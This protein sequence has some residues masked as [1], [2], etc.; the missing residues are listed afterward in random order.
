[1]MKKKYVL[2]FVGF[3]FSLIFFSCAS[4]KQPK[5][6]FKPLDYTNDDVVNAEI[7]RI[8]NLKTTEPVKALWRAILLQNDD[9]I[10]ECQ[11]IVK[12]QYDF[13]LEEK[14]YFEARTYYIS[15]KN[16]SWNFGKNEE[17]KLKSLFVQD[18]PGFSINSQ[19]LPKTLNDCLN[20]TVTIWVDRGVK[21]ENGA[22]YADIVLGSGF[23]IDERGYIVTNH[24]VIESMV[25]PKYEGYSRLYI[26]LLSDSDTKIPAKVVGY[27]SKLDLALLK[28]EIKPEF[29]LSLGSSSDLSVGDKVSAIGTPLGLEGTLTSGIVSATGRKL[30]TLGDVFQIDAAVNSGNS[31]G[32]LIDENMKVQAIVFAGILQYQGLNFAIPVEY[33]KQEL[34]ILYNE[35]EVLHPWIGAYGH[36]KKSGNKKIGLEIQ[37]TMPGSPSY[38]NGLKSGDVITKIEDSNI[39]SLED[40]QLAFMSYQ[41]GTMVKITYLENGEDETSKCIYLEKRP[42]NPSTEFYKSDLISGSFI[43]LFGMELASSSSMNHKEYVVRNVIKGSSADELNFSENDK[44]TVQNV[45]LNDENSIIFAQIYAQRKK[46]GFL[47]VTMILSTSYDS[48]YYF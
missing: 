2:V 12:N 34:P 22:G 4:V 48:P 5:E 31:G 21:I 17:E 40:L 13:A 29:I 1:M 6:V 8:N 26:K 37:Y 32:P 20:A 18:V 9:V 30:L 7:E 45:V 39:T 19:K 16:S 25:N 35:D 33:L 46:K 10:K 23:F 38:L 15:L 11:E 28:A 24:H 44:I 36:T 27:D 47:D 42:E 14:N 41:P 43:P 3:V